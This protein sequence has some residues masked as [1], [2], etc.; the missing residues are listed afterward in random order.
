M[1]GNLNLRIEV[2]VE[3][4]HGGIATVVDDDGTARGIDSLAGGVWHDAIEP[5]RIECKVI[6][7][8]EIYFGAAKH[9]QGSEVFKR[10]RTR[11]ACHEGV[12]DL[13]DSVHELRRDIGRPVG[14]GL[15]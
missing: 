1:I 5:G 15:V 6:G 2:E 7:R 4:I 9:I 12:I 13:G 11:P 8:G 3:H 10:Q 14:I